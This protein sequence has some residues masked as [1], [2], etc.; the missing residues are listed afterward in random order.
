MYSLTKNERKE[1]W[2]KKKESKGGQASASSEAVKW[3]ILTAHDG[4]EGIQAVQ[5]VECILLVCSHSDLTISQ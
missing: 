2:G 1:N 4:E 5:S 3:V